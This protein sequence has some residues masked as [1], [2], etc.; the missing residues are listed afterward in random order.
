MFD[1]DLDMCN[2][3]ENESDTLD[4]GDL[5]DGYHNKYERVPGEKTGFDFFKNPG[6]LPGE[7]CSNIFEGNYFLPDIWYSADDIFT[8][9][10]GILFKTWLDHENPTNIIYIYYMK[11]DSHKE[12]REIEKIEI[13]ED[14]KFIYK[15]CVTQNI[16]EHGWKA[17]AITY[18][19]LEER[20]TEHSG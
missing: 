12:P 2:N 20:F 8:K 19:K 13:S 17:V 4:W 1:L 5:Y 16:S 6:K 10:E 9:S 7:I 18:N 14:G 3:I 11:Y 15:D